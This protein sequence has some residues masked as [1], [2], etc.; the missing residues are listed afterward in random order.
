[1][2]LYLRGD[3]LGTFEALRG[4]G[5]NLDRIVTLSGA[6]ALGESD[7]IYKVVVEQVNPGATE[8]RNG[9][10]VTIYD[11]QGK[12]VM[13]RTG[14]QPDEQQGLAS[15]DEHLVFTSAR[16]VIDLNGLPAEAETLTYTHGENDAGDPSIGDND[17]ELDFEDFPCLARA[18]MLMTE[19]GPRPVERLRPGDRLRGEDGALRRVIWCA[20][21]KVDLS[22]APD[23]ARPIRIAAGS[24]GPGRPT[25]NL[26]VS[27]Q[28]RI[29]LHAPRG[30]PGRGSSGPVLVPARALTG[31]PGIRQMAGRRHIGYVA[32]LLDR[33]AVISAE[34]APVESFFPGPQGLRSLGPALAADLFELIPGLA[35]HGVTTY[36]PPACPL[37]SMQEGRQLVRALAGA[38]PAP[39]AR[40]A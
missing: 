2:T 37:L 24:L 31:L 33:H 40:A 25:R 30:L 20:E 13:P 26:T 17:G 7:E 15:G 32:I 12:T 34:G 4:E 36:G 35:E 14:A 8:F 23:R 27:P 29:A 1:M 9:Q 22:G 18:T 10:F 3:Q 6:K 11:S 5:N 19:S 21:R 39:G 38:E 28:H 16:F